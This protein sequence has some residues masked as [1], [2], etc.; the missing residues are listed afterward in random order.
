MKTIEVVAAI[1][2][3]NNRILCTQRADDGRFLSL[4]WEFPGGKIEENESHQ[5][6]LKREIK[7][8]LNLNINVLEHFITVDYTYPHFRIIMHAYMCEMLNNDFTLNEHNHF[9]WLL[10]KDL[11]QL[12]WSEADKEIVEKIIKK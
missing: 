3:K 9:K 8:E 7:E 12:D 11:N 10:A 5:E 4:K 6:A 2:K 1:I